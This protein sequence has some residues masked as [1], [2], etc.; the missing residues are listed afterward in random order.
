MIEAVG[1]IDP[2]RAGDAETIDLTGEIVIPGFVQAHVHL[3][4]TPFRGLAEGLEL[5]PWL[6]T[7]VLP[8]E[9]AHDPQTLYAA[10][11]L[12]IAELLLGGCTTILDFGSVNHYSVVF[13][14]AREMGIRFVGGNTMMDAGQNVPKAI[15]QT[16]DAALATSIELFGRWHGAAQGRL[17]YAVTPRFLLSCSEAL[18]RESLALAREHDLLW[19][20]HLAEQQAE[21]AAVRKATGMASAD[22]L[23]TLD[24]AGTRMAFA[25]AVHLLEGEKRQLADWRAGVL[26]CPRANSKLASGRAPVPEYRRMGLAVG[27]G[28]DGSACN[29]KLDMFE[30]M[31]AAGALQDLAHGPA[32]LPSAALFT[33]ATIDGA[34]AIGLG[35]EVGAIEP[36]RRADLVVLDLTG[37]P[38]VSAAEPLETIVHAGDA[39]AVKRVMIDG[40]WVVKEGRLLTADPDEVAAEA[41]RAAAI[42]KERVFV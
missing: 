32:A 16:K 41:A 15:R 39:R 40:R 30:E 7:R 12:G 23:D 4:Q 10:A 14:A 19:H 20:T 27:L 37:A 24:A 36:G 29:N 25:H 13:Q 6:A 42:L 21:V 9:A 18:L 28:S 5:L 34:R 33:M 38:F 1:K 17:R 35:G 3:A 8:L 2:A 11:R 31:R 26:H 22:Y